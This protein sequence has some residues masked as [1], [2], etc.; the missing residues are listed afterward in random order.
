METV[1]R[2]GVK[3]FITIK[4]LLYFCRCQCELCVAMPTQDESI[5]CREQ[6]V[7]HKIPDTVKCITSHEN[8]SAVCL[9][10]D[11][12]EVAYMT[13]KQY[14]H[15][16]YENNWKRYTAYRQFI[17]WIYHH[18]GEKVRIPIPARVVHKIRE[19]FPLQ[20]GQHVGFTY[21]D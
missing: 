11:V 1:H 8:F 18:L 9:N 6:K 19:T 4:L 3:F 15:L 2:R 16:D 5:C 14:V 21:A 13:Y 7:V 10:E 12:L 20:E 17:R